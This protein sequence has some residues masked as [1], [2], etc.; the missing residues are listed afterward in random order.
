M[1]SVVAFLAALIVILGGVWVLRR[2]V[3]RLR[4]VRG[5]DALSPRE[6]D[7][8]LEEARA[9]ALELEW[10]DITLERLDRHDTIQQHVE[11]LSRP[12][13]PFEQLSR[14][15]RSDTP[16]IAALGLSA[17]A[18]R[19]EHLDQWRIDA[20]RLLASCSSPV[21]PFVYRTL[22]DMPGRAG[23][24]QAR[25]RRRLAGARRFHRAT[26]RPRRASGRRDLPAEPAC[27]LRGSPRGVRRP[28]RVLS[29][30]AMLCVDTGRVAWTASWPATSICPSYS[31]GAASAVAR[32]PS[33]AASQRSA[34]SAAMQPIPAAV[35][36]WRYVW[37]TTSPPA[38]TPSTLVSVEPG[39]VTM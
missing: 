28:V 18:R 13:V 9:A 11:R 1:D 2:L 27:A 4:G 30:C 39:F 33:R 24:L 34:S 16:G 26:P 38:K 37:S 5:R 35:T 31:R 21:E 22:L 6:V 14:L 25:R 7:S 32:W 3:E 20:I 8:A 15:A 12:D 23:T 19:G 10:A 17:I 36:A 29:R